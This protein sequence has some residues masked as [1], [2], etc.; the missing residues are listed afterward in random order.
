MHKILI[1]EDNN[2]IRTLLHENF[3]KEGYKVF[4]SNSILEAKNQLNLDPD[5]IIL[6]WMLPDGQGLDFLS[7]VKNKDFRIPV[8]FLTA[9]VELVD[10][11]LGL[12]MGANDYM[13]K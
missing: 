8:I 2:N 9:R 10:K 1:V 5:L 6:D 7:V 3:V 12:E 11:I 13:T 4:T